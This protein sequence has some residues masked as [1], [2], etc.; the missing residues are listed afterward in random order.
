MAYCQANRQNAE[1]RPL[2]KQVRSASSF[3][4]LDIAAVGKTHALARIEAMRVMTGTAAG[5]LNLHTAGLCAQHA[6]TIEQRGSDPA[7]A[8][9]FLHRKLHDLCD[10]RAVMQLS[11]MRTFATR[12]LPHLPPRPERRSAHPHIAPDTADRSVRGEMLHPPAR[13]S[14]GIPPQRPSRSQSG[15]YQQNKAAR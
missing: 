1:R 9:A 12:S 3:Q 7:S 6:G 15:S 8:A 5:K 2:F 10:A 14:A 13:R 11:S 4:G